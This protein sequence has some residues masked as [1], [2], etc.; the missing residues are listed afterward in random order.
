MSREI[1]RELFASLIKL[2]ENSWNGYS[3]LIDGNFIKRVYASSDQEAIKEF[4]NWIDERNKVTTIKGEPAKGVGGLHQLKLD[5]KKLEEIK[6]GTLKYGE[7]FN[8]FDPYKDMYR[9]DVFQGK[10]KLGTFITNIPHKINQYIKCLKYDEMYEEGKCSIYIY[11]NE[12]T[13]SLSEQ[14]KEGI[15]WC[16]D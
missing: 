1:A 8:E 13:L 4:R 5:E 3:I 16:K 11:K 15:N 7:S 10:E 6:N 14:R 9:A 2:G 12:I